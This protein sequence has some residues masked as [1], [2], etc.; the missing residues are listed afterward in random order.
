M[1]IISKG[2]ILAGGKGT[3][4]MPLTKDRP[5]PMVEIHGKPFLEYLIDLLKESGITRVLIL[6]GHM[7]EKI[8]DYFGDGSRF[9]IEISY[10]Y[11]E[12]E[13]ETGARLRNAKGLIDDEFLLLYCDNYWP[14]KLQKL[15]AF[16]RTHGSTATMVVYSNKDKYSKNNVHVGQDGIIELYDKSRTAENL[17]GIDVGFFLLKKSALELLPEGNPSFEAEILPQLVE[18]KQLAGFFTDHR[19]YTIGSLERFEQAVEFLKPKK[20]VLLDRDGVINKK[21]PKAEYVKTWSEFQ[22]IPGALDAIAELTQKGYGLYILTNQPGIA[23]E[24]LSENDLHDIH[25]HML[26]EIRE[27]GGEI[28][29]IYVCPHGWDDGC[30]CRKPKPGMLFQAAR[31]HRFD[32]TKAVYVGDDGRD[33]E[34][35]EAADTQFIMVPSDIGIAAAVDKLL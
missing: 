35:A 11:S 3:R 33:G 25:E 32:L 28:A 30:E 14:L 34:A 8:S 10:H 13:A 5:K 31:E 29:G 26:T 24:S 1:N 4:L 22:F 2:V 17:N 20:I 15:Q 16:H 6:T 19:Y 7:A 23:R 12:P 21:A 18:K 27:K 9:G